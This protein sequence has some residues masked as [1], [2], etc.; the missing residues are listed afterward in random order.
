MPAVSKL[1]MPICWWHK[2]VLYKS[3]CKQLIN[4]RS[5]CIGMVSFKDT[6]IEYRLDADSPTVPKFEELVLKIWCLCLT[7]YAKIRKFSPQLFSN[8][9]LCHDNMAEITDVYS[10]VFLI[11]DLECWSLWRR[12][13]CFFHQCVF[14]DPPKNIVID[15]QSKWRLVKPNSLEWS[16]IT[17]SNGHLTWD[18][19]KVKF[20]EALG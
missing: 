2:P 8:S 14:G 16:S 18:A 11:L 12:I 6:F 10:K 20:Q 17:N 13:V 4:S 9:C 5:Q 3:K 19:F 1:F 15:V 7:N